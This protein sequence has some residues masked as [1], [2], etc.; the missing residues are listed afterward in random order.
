MPRVISGDLIQLQVYCLAADQIGINNYFFRVNAST[1]GYMYTDLLNWAQVNVYPLY[2][3]LMPVTA[4]VYGPQI[5]K[6]SPG[7][8]FPAM[9]VVN[10]QVG[11]A[12]GNLAPRQ[13]CPMLQKQTGVRGAKGRGRIF[14]PFFSDLFITGAGHLSGAGQAITNNIGNTLLSNLTV[15]P[16][17]GG[18]TAALVPVLVNQKTLATID[19]TGFNNPIKLGT[20]KRRG[21]FGKPNSLPF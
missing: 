19:L 4:Q 11:T 7:P 2:V 5:R 21:D 12:T 9:N 14:L 16:T 8:F 15:G 13:S 18:D 10:A 1:A 3:P 17:I 20:Q 6:I